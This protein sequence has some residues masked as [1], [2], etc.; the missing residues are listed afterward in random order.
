MEDFL[1]QLPKTTT[2]VLK[3]LYVL[4][5]IELMNDEKNDG[6]FEKVGNLLEKHTLTYEQL[7]RLYVHT[8]LDA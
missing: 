5:M 3:A 2:L 1:L 7:I 4:P 6:S 8:H